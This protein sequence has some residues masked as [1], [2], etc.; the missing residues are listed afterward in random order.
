MPRSH[1]ILADG[2]Q[3]RFRNTVALDGLELAVPRGTVYGLL[4][5]T[6]PVKPRRYGSSPLCCAR[7]AAGPKWPDLMS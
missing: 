4:G 2:V 7:T 1:A 3:K 5:Q 6:A